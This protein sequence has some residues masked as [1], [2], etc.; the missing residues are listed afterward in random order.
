MTESKY[1]QLAQR[2]AQIE[3]KLQSRQ[4]LEAKLLKY[5]TDNTKYLEVLQK[6]EKRFDYLNSRLQAH[7]NKECVL[8][9]VSRYVDRLGSADILVNFHFQLMK[10][11]NWGDD[12]WEQRGASLFTIH[13]WFTMIMK[14]EDPETSINSKVSF[15]I[16]E[17]ESAE[18]IVDSFEDLPLGVDD[19]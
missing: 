13:E 8:T 1:G 19:V 5:A 15:K 17:E 4:T 12:F 9:E 16:L 3:A 6:Q 18:D 10:A 7:I 11:Y 2:V 14:V